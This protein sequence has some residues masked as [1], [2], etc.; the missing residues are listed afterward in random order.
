MT[1]AQKMEQIANLLAE[2]LMTESA[3]MSS[4]LISDAIDIATK[5]KSESANRW[6]HNELSK[7]IKAYGELQLNRKIN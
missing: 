3:D 5:N 2:V 1:K 7:N 6:L 4:K